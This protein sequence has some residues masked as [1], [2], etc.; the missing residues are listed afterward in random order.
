MKQ[1]S[2]RWTT[3]LSFLALAGCGGD[4]GEETATGTIEVV[5]TDVAP[6]LPARLVAV[7]VEEGAAVRAGDTLA[8]LRTSTVGG[9]VAG[10]EAGVQ[11]A[12]AALRE[13]ENGARPQ[14]EQQA[15]AELQAA[16][17]EATRTARDVERYRRLLDVGGIA[18]QQYAAAV[19]A[20]RVA[21][22]RRDAAREG[23]R[24][25][26]EGPRRERIDAARAQV[27]GARAALQSARQ[28]QGDLTLVAPVDG[29]VMGRWAEPGE[30]LAAGEAVLTV[31]E[32]RRPWTRIYVNQKALPRLRPGQE[33]AARLDGM[34]DRPFRGRIAAINDRAEF[35]P[36]VA[37]TEAERADLLFGVRVELL[38]T[39]GTL[40][41]GLPA[42]VVLP[43][44]AP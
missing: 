23:L 28:T 32:T 26:R 22:G 35:T 40:K 41:P 10:R 30:V 19:A 12:E 2:V 42:T 44:E 14:E 34:P 4:G 13:M 24:L 1:I 31:G 37:L 25:V 33:V 18:R 36:R 15:A 17:A 20:A 11:A 8:I 6:M 39:T 5:E 7:R 16:E 21:D 9:E 27:A 29:V 38:D 3:V 43:P